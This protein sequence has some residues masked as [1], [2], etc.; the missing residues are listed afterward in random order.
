[1]GE[2]RARV[3]KSE[4]KAA[5]AAEAEGDEE[6]E[7]DEAASAAAV[8]KVE[9]EEKRK[10]QAKAKRAAAS[11]AARKESPSD[12]VPG[13]SGGGG[14]ASGAEVVDKEESPRIKA[15]EA[16]L[17]ALQKVIASLNSSSAPSSSPPSALGQM[18][19]SMQHGSSAQ[20]SMTMVVPPL[21]YAN[22]GAG[23][24]GAVIAASMQLAMHGS[25]NQRISL[26]FPGHG[27]GQR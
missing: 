1:V 16:Q 15:L 14:G 21:S 23:G 9:A 22:D 13:A 5:A 24:F 10:N 4:E 20:G 2:K 7:A 11:R 8:A 25:L 19:T 18:F 17:A 26:L 3:T 6:E 27:G 12:T